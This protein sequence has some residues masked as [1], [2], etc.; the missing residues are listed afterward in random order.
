[1]YKEICNLLTKFRINNVIAKV[2]KNKI[3]IL[4]YHGIRNEITFNDFKKYQH[5]NV[6]KNDFFNQMKYLKKNYTIISLSEALKI[7]RSGENKKS[8]LLAITFD[9]GYLNNYLY[10]WPICR[11]LGIKFTLYVATNFIENQSML[12]TDRIAMAL[13]ETKC[14]QL[15]INI[16]NVTYKFSL[17]TIRDRSIASNKILEI[18]KYVNVKNL[19]N[20]VQLIEKK[21]KVCYNKN[22]ETKTMY[23]PCNWNQ[24]KEMVS[25]G[26]VEVGAHTVNHKI[27][28]QL[29]KAEILTEL[30]DAKKIIEERISGTCNHFAYPNGK[31]EDFNSES[32]L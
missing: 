12:W 17:A 23:K 19:L 1:M 31:K 26:L 10:A 18:L 28:T 22:G 14:A 20:N 6:L 5:L 9:D 3:P 16:E 11:E 7:L 13:K 30:L 2:N 21:L 24:L 4:M 15:D 8:G 29:P 25:S 27:L 32:H